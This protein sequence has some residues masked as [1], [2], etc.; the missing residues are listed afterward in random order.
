MLAIGA[1]SMGLA[2]ATNTPEFLLH[3]EEAEKLAEAG[4]RVSR[5]YPTILTAKQRDHALFMSTLGVIAYSHAMAYFRR[6]AEEAKPVNQQG[7][8]L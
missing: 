6:K 3:G 1:V 5:H 8:M 7:M 4:V 2:A